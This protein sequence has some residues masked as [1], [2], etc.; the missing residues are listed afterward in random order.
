VTAWK[1]VTDGLSKGVVWLNGH[2]LGRY[3]SVGPQQALY[4]PEQWL[5]AENV[6]VIFDEQGCNPADVKLVVC[7]SFR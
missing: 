2:H 5:Q 3:W 1:L 4:V 6:M 7:E